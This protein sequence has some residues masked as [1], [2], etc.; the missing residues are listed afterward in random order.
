MIDAARIQHDPGP[1]RPILSW[2]NPRFGPILDISGLRPAHPEPDFWIYRTALGRT[3][4]LFYTDNKPFSMGC[5]TDGSEALI[6][7]LGEAVERYASYNSYEISELKTMPYGECPMSA[8]FAKC[9]DD[10]PCSKIH[11]RVPHDLLLTHTKMEFLKDGAECWIPAPY[12][13]LDFMPKTRQPFVFIPIST[14]TA[15]YPNLPTALFTAFREVV[16]RD[17]MMSFWHN[18]T[19]LPELNLDSDELPPSLSDRVDRVRRAG[20]QV[21][22]FDMSTDIRFP[23]VYCAI[24]SDRRP[25][26]G[27]GGSCGSDPLRACTG[28]IDE[29]IGIRR[30]LLTLPRPVHSFDNFDSVQELADHSSLFAAWKDSPAYDFLLKVEPNYISFDEFATQKW[31]P[32]PCTMEDHRSLASQME[33]LGLTVLWKDLTTPDIQHWG[34]C[35]KVVVPEMVPLSLSHNIRFLAT[36]RLLRNRSVEGTPSVRHFNPYPHPYA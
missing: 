6:K 8:R 4:G 24:E 33:E 16:E 19:Q 5:S 21:R 9:A 32:N 14:G 15:F 35:V 22:L 25:Y 1:C 29:A 36:P 27:T 10:E 20:L 7:V 34:Y 30:T 26:Y 31:W 13:H 3:L 23:T 11:K 12:V 17:A 18:R 28:A 2:V